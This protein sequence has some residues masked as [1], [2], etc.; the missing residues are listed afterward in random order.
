MALIDLAPLMFVTV[1]G[2]L[3][4]ATAIQNGRLLRM[5]LE[6]FP[7]EAAQHAALT[8]PGRHPEKALFFL[9]SNE[10]PLLSSDES[11]WRMRQ[12]FVHLL[13]A[14]VLVPSLALV[15]GAIGIIFLH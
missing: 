14:S 15:A 7:T 3:W 5:F 11:V 12:R 13:F 10:V 8:A 9:R 6:R 2:V 4:S 1:V